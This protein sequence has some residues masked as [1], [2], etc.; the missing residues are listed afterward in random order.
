[1][2][3]YVFGLVFLFSLM[4]CGEDID[5]FIPRTNPVVDGDISRLT[6]K[7]KQDI[8]GDIHYT[9]SCPCF[10]DYAFEFGK[11]L[12]LVIPPQFVDIAQYPCITGEYQLDVTICDEKG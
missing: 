3:K 8:A 12:V 2:G 5:I 11:D 9:V 1:M 6:T 10:G 7:L 4:S